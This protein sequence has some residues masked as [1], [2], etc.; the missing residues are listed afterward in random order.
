MKK[1]DPPETAMSEKSQGEV[2]G[3]NEVVFLG[4]I[5]EN[6][7][8]TL[9]NRQGEGVFCGGTLLPHRSAVGE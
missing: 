4:K 7:H 5:R 2:F 1:G 8:R 6:C 9:L 3:K